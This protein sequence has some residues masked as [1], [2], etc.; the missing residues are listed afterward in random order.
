[1]TDYAAPS[2]DDLDNGTLAFEPN[3]TVFVRTHSKKE[4]F[5]RKLTLFVRDGATAA[6][7]YTDASMP[8]PNRDR[9]AVWN[10]PHNLFSA[11]LDTPLEVFYQL[12]EG[13]E[14]SS[15]QMLRFK[16]RFEE[17]QHV[18]L[19]AHNYIVF[20][21]SFFT[22]VPPP[23]LP[24]YA[25]LTRTVAQATRYE[26]SHP[27]LASVDANGKVSLRSNTADQ[28]LTITA[29][30]AADASLG[31]YTL[32]VSGIREL[33]LLSIDSEMT[34]QGAAAMAAAVE[35]RQP[36]AE[37]FNR[38]LQLYGNPEAGLA[39][40]LGLE[41]KGLLGAAQGAG[42]VTVLDLDNLVIVTAPGSRQGYGVAISDSIEIR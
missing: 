23:N 28:P 35:Q 16:A 7:I 24:E 32:Q 31:S 3:G 14:R 27:E 11:Y 21:D 15:V 20:H 2:I 10:I 18:R 5:T 42:E 30:D 9:E 39:N 1:M 12:G 33:S 13:E 34:A 26:S 17:P 8:T 37:E 25:Q 29:F 19:H 4:W 38:F 22:A 41:P 40:Y 36:S 6:L